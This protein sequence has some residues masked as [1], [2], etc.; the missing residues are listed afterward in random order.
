[1]LF[2]GLRGLLSRHQEVHE[3]FVSNLEVSISVYSPDK[4]DDFIFP[5]Q[6]P[7]LLQKELEILKQ[8]L[9][10]SSCCDQIKGIDHV[11]IITSQ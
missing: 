7:V 10:G 4:P 8:D 1:M 5:R 2:H 6:V 3:L 11:E 9:I